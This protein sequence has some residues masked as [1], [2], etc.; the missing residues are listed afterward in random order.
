LTQKEGR[1]LGG[2]LGVAAVGVVV[3]GG[4]VA[5]GAQSA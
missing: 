2:P 4:A 1:P 5:A 3:G